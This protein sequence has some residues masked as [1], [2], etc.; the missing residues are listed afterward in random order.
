MVS[1]GAGL[2]WLW[3]IGLDGKIVFVNEVLCPLFAAWG[4]FEEFSTYDTL[5]RNRAN[6]LADIRTVG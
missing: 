6:L 2:L 3:S 1:A 4:F 5:A